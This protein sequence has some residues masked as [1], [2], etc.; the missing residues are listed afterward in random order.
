MLNNKINSVK[1]TLQEEF[2]IKISFIDKK[3][4]NAATAEEV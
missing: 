4:T 3:I 1:E 2:N